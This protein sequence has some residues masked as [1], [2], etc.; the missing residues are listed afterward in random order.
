MA[1]FYLLA[2]CRMGR[3]VFWLPWWCLAVYRQ[4]NGSLDLLLLWF[5][6]ELEP[7]A[8]CFRRLSQNG[9]F[10]LYGNFSLSI[11]KSGLE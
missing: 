5:P 7:L 9:N 6:W 4:P 2:P 11:Q 1:P 8:S 3:T 10:S